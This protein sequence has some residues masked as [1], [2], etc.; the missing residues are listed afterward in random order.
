MVDHSLD[1]T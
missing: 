1:L